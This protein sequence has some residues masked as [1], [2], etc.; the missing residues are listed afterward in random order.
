M[1][2][3][4][5]RGQSTAQLHFGYVPKYSR[6]FAFDTVVFVQGSQAQIWRLTSPLNL[7]KLLYDKRLVVESVGCV[8]ENLNNTWTTLSPV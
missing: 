3:D 2:P 6:S 7:I 5:G 1:L 8:V 4:S